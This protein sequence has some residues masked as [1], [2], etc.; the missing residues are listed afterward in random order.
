MAAS[1]CCTRNHF[2][3]GLSVATRCCDILR[4]CSYLDKFAVSSAMAALSSAAT[5][6]DLSKPG[7]IKCRHLLFP[8][9]AHTC[10]FYRKYSTGRT[11]GGWGLCK[12]YFTA[13]LFSVS[14]S[15][16]LARCRSRKIAVSVVATV[17]PRGISPHIG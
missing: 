5:T 12:C 10:E 6:Q 15:Y 1:F 3:V 17:T 2:C 7:P 4:P 11:A 16:I 9:R 14:I 13:Q 8:C